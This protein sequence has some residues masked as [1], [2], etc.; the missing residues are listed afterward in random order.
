MRGGYSFRERLG[1]RLVLAKVFGE[2][3][4]KY[5]DLIYSDKN[6]ERECDYIEKMFSQYS[7]RDTKEVLDIG[8]GTAGHA[9]LLA[10]RGY[11]VYAADASSY[12]LGIGK[13]KAL[14]A[15]IAERITFRRCD[16]RELTTGRHFDACVSLFATLNYLLTYEDLLRTFDAIGKQLRRDGLLI[17]DFWNGPAVLTERPSER[18]KVIKRNSVRLTRTAKPILDS[19]TN[20]VSIEYSVLVIEDGRPKEDFKE[21]HTVRYFFPEEIRYFLKL[22]GF[23]VLSMH[24]YL[25]P[26]L[27]LTSGDWNASVIARLGS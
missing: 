26:K 6:Y 10:K 9:I 15:G 24:P 21:T 3:Y 20:T 17:F 27:K 2:R 23:R 4:S 14:G 25:K 7:S 19:I 11:F 22:C 13:S 18:M 8:C 16:I 1:S 12:M 5:Y